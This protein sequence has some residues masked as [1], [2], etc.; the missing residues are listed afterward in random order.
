M[1]R[2]TSSLFIILPVLT[3]AVLTGSEEI[4]REER[5]NGPVG[6]VVILISCLLHFCFNAA[7]RFLPSS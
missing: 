4:E 3:G 2:L 5:Y 1:D 6:G 7:K